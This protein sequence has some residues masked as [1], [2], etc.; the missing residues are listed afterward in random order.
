MGVKRVKGFGVSGNVRQRRTIAVDPDLWSDFADRCR[1]E[2]VSISGGVDRLVR[3]LL[4]GG[5]LGE[6]IARFEQPICVIEPEAKLQKVT[7]E[8]PEIIYNDELWAL[9]ELEG[10]SCIIDPDFAEEWLAEREVNPTDYYAPVKPCPY[11]HCDVDDWDKERLA[12]LYALYPATYFDHAAV[13][14]GQ[15]SVRDREKSVEQLAA[16]QAALDEEKAIIW[17]EQEA[18]RRKELKLPPTDHKILVYDNQELIDQGLLWLETFGFYARVF[19]PGRGWGHLE[20]RPHLNFVT[21]ETCHFRMPYLDF[22]HYKK[23][24]EFGENLNL[25]DIRAFSCNK[26]HEEAEEKLNRAQQGWAAEYRSSEFI[27][28]MQVYVDNSPEWLNSEVSCHDDGEVDLGQQRFWAIAQIVCD[29]RL[30]VSILEDSLNKAKNARVK[31]APSPKKEKVAT[32]FGK[33]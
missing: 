32:G 9:W 7:K 13:E 22:D 5:D 26:D 1:D 21:E 16:E 4:N 12:A 10:F 6:A 14:V 31:L 19:I 8:K 25:L 27:R 33:R 11:V 17:R 30:M 24:S 20:D 2:K 28:L 3:Q 15:K 18:D 23:P 29:R